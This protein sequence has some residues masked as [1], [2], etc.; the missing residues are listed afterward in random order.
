MRRTR[1]TPARRLL[2]PVAIAAALALAAPA[3][4][5]TIVYQCGSAVC[6]VDPDSGGKP[7]Q[8][9][10]QGR[11][12]GLTRDGR[13]ASWVDPSGTLVQAPVAGGEPR[14]VPFT[15]EVANQ[16]SMSPDGTRYLWWYPGP[17][18]FGGLNA[19]W[20]RRLTVVQSE[21]EGVAFC[22]FCVTTHG[23]LG[24][25]TAIGAFP[26][27]PVRGEPSEICRLA[28]TAEEPGVSGSCVQVLATDSRAGIVF[29]SANAA[30]TEVAVLMPGVTTGVSGRIVRYSLS[31]GGRSRT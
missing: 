7:R 25:N 9:T 15:G 28:S 18:G 4:A 30:G 14:T 2:P 22:G 1:I 19:V 5:S 23:W 10:A 6:A 11:M 27:D 8:L 13:T 12:A 31:T 16:P 3:G 26:S 21:T 20:T 24:T 29:P 17:D